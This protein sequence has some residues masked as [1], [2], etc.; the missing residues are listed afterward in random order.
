[1]RNLCGTSL[2]ALRKA[3]LLRVFFLYLLIMNYAPMPACAHTCARAHMRTRTRTHAAV[4]FF[5]VTP[6]HA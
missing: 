3:M 6:I 5:D 1:M 4:H 2:I